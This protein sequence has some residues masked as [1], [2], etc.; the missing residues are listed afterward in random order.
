[1]HFQQKLTVNDASVIIGKK[2]LVA[3]G[4]DFWSPL[5]ILSL[6]C[7]KSRFRFSILTF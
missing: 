3:L 2:E 1:M 5:G 6:F 7:L 4:D